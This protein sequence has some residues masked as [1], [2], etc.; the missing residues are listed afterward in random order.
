MTARLALP[1]GLRR[2]GVTGEATSPDLD[3]GPR[4]PRTVSLG[5][6][7]AYAEGAVFLAAGTRNPA[8]TVGGGAAAGLA[9]LLLGVLVLGL[10]TLTRTGSRLARACLLLPLVTAAAVLVRDAGLAWELRVGPVLAAAAVTVL[11]TL[12]PASR[13]W[14]GDDATTLGT[15]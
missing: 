3:E 4:R 14:F 12:V 13:Q 9:F 11:L 15:P 8:G 6:L 2:R 10:T 1:R 5:L 7:L